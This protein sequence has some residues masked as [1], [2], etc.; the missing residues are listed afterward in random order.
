MKRTV[1]IFLVTLLLI[2]APAMANDSLKISNLRFNNAQWFDLWF[3]NY[4]RAQIRAH[5]KEVILDSSKKLLY[6]GGHFCKRK[7]N[8]DAGV[9]FIHG[10]IGLKAWVV[11]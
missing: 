7:Y 5:I 4:R 9:G 11:L 2:P 3:I 1:V 6:L 10:G 8:T